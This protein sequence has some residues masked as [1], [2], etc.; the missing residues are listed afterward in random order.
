MERARGG[1]WGR[2]LTATGEGDG[3]E[4]WYYG[5]EKGDAWVGGCSCA[6]TRRMSVE[7]VLGQ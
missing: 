5:M 1:R 6:E 4:Y 7:G 3:L 2:L